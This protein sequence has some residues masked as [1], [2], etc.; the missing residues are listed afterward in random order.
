MKNKLLLLI[1]ACII[2]ACDKK[3]APVIDES[4]VPDNVPTTWQEHWFEHNQLLKLA[5]FDDHVALY[6]DD[7]MDSN[8]SW[9]LR[10][11]SSM[12]EYVKNIYGTFGT[13]EHLFVVLHADKYYGGHPSTFFDE[14]HDFRNVIDIGQANSWADS[15]NWNLDVIAHEIG[16]IVEG[17]SKGVHRSPAFPIWHD[18][19]WMEIFQYDLYKKLGWQSE[20]QRWYDAMES[21]TDNYPKEGTRWFKDWFY[22]IYRDYGETVVLNDF[23]SLLAVHFAKAS[24]EDGYFRYTRDLNFGE[25]IHFWS[26]AAQADL[27]DLALTAFGEKD[28][29]GNNWIDQFEQA[30]DD[31]AGISY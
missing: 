24:I 11:S 28:E 3:M 12:W 15:S 13:E 7:D 27:K 16:H 23:F 22:P 2:L 19:K 6:Y 21:V 29:H 26:G 17:A 8:I 14:S 9:P 30:K 25:F 1:T 4:Q 10:A 20:A 31:F 5:S 18:S